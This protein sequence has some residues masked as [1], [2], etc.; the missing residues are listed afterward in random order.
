MVKAKSM[1]RRQ[2]HGTSPQRRHASSHLML[3]NAPG[4]QAATLFETIKRVACETTR[5]GA[6][7]HIY[8]ITCYF[9]PD[10]L[11]KFA[12]SMRTTIKTEGGRLT[13]ITVAVDVGEWL[14]CQLSEK[15]LA[16]EMAGATG[17]P[18][19]F[20]NVLPVQFPGRLMHAKAY[21]AIQPG[22]EKEK[23][24]FVVITSGNATSPGLGL[25]ERSNLELATV[26]TDPES[27][28]T[29]EGVISQLAEH[30]VSPADALKK[31]KY[32]G[33]LALFCRGSFYHKWQGSLGS[34][35]R[36][37][38]TLTE[39]GVAE[40]D[41]NQAT[42]KRYAPD[43]ES[44]SR[45]PLQIQGIFE[46]NPKP[47]PDAFWRTYGIDTLLGYWL[48]KSVAKL[49]DEV[50]GRQVDAYL[51]EID[52]LT[53]PRRVRRQSLLLEPEVEEWAR[54]GWIKEDSAVIEAWCNR[55]EKFRKDRDLL[56][57]RLH[58]F[59]KLPE[60]VLVGESRITVRRTFDLL[61]EQLMLKPLSK[62]PMAVGTKAVLKKFIADS[63]TLTE[64]DAELNRLA[65]AAQDYLRGHAAGAK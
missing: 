20:V 42:F 63:L 55:V 46:D 62:R 45:D 25:R 49:A 59:E 32:L 27:L 28:S 30:E 3:T 13:G 22:E 19:K 15:A 39:K 51:D 35:I 50:L 37:K 6:R 11:R 16:R 23:K 26:L 61:K 33:A 1:A 43:S 10:A 56:K 21:A 64:L 48:P 60:E 54:N 38:L 31:D 24:G 14:R 57:S 2:S 52:R 9:D 36:F 47:F 40:R 29:F 5:S 8:V 44:M 4:T 12:S 58:P 53:A 41:R 7:R 17:V 18:L 65:K 34:A